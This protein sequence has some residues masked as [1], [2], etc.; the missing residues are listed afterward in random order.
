MHNHNDLRQL[1]NNRRVVQLLQ[2]RF[3]QLHLVVELTFE[4]LLDGEHSCKSK[5]QSDLNDKRIKQE[6]D[7]NPHHQGR[8]RRSQPG[9]GKGVLAQFASTLYAWL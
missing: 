3:V 1:T 4:E 9:G 2:R 7:L 8:R 6:A 5:I